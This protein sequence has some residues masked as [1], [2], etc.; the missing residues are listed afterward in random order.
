MASGGIRTADDV[1]KA[2]ALGADGAV[3]GTTEL[4]AFGCTRCSNC[5]R[6]RGCPFGLTTTDPELSQLVDPDW[7]AQ[8]LSNLYESFRRQLED[9]LRRVGLKS[10]RELRGRTD[11]LVYRRQTGARP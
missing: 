2:I 4:V 10:I 6:G 7:G 3:L 8:R 5:E 1:A 11:L 9:I